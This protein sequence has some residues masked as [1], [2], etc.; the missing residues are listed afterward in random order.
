MSINNNSTIYSACYAAKQRWDIALED[1]VLCVSKDPKFIKGYFRLSAAQ[2][3]L[4]QY[5][6]AEATLKAVLQLEP[7]INSF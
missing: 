6:D 4:K 3:E 7:G 1:A 5:S 2:M